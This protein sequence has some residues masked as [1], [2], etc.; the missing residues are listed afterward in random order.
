MLDLIPES[1]LVLP[2]KYLKTGPDKSSS[3]YRQEFK[4]PSG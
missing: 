4:L 3:H 2:E 1:L